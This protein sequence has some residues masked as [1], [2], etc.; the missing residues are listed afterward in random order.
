MPHAPANSMT[1]S[2]P[3]SRRAGILVPLFSIPSSASWGIGEIGDL[4]PLTR[5]LESAGQRFVQLLPINELPLHER[6]PYSALSAMAIDPQFITMNAVED[7]DALGGESSLDGGLRRRLEV[8]RSAGAV[9]YDQVRSLKHAVLHRAYTHFRD[10]EW[11]SGTRRAAA[12][13]VYMESQAWWLD[14]YALF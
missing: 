1:R 14:D 2:Q 3:G 6:S 4:D 8:V 7:F 9:Q 12:F 5:W 11:K 13:R 10:R